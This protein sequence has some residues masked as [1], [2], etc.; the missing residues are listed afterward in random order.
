VAAVRTVRTGAWD[1]RDASG[2][3]AA[4][5]DL[6]LR[7]RACENP[8]AGEEL[9]RREIVPAARAVGEGQRHRL[10]GAAPDGEVE[11]SGHQTRTITLVPRA[12]AY[13]AHCSHFLHAQMGMT[14]SILVD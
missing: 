8:R 1:K 10:A 5:F 3:M 2:L 13:R 14:D 4:Q 9:A 11:L 7:R 12:G 6:P